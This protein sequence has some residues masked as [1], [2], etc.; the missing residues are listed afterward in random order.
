MSAASIRAGARVGATLL[1]IFFALSMPSSRVESQVSVS[2]TPAS[3]PTPACPPSLVA[4]GHDYHG[5]TLALCSFSG[6][7]LTNATFNGATL[8]GVVFIKTNLTGADFS[9]ATFADSGNATLPTDFTFANLTNAKLIG[10]KFNGATYFTYSTLTCADFSQTNINNGNAIFGDTPLAID[11]AQS[12]RTKF[13]NTTMNCEFVAQWNRLDL[14]GAQISACA[15]ELQ[16]ATG[17]PGYDFSGGLYAGVVFDNLDLA[18]SK[19]TGAVLEHASFQGATLDNA[20]GL[21]GTTATPSRLSAAKFNKASVQNV[22]LSNAQLYGA[23]FTNANLTNSCLAGSFLSA[24]TATTPPI[25]TA[26]V[27]DGAHLRNVNLAS[28]KLQGA[29]F[30]FASFYGSFGGATPAFPCKTNCAQPGFTCSC[31]TA[32]GA[33][34]TGANFSNAYLFGVDFTGATT[35][36]NGTQFGSAI[37]TGAS[38]A[39]A[40]FQVKGGAAPDFTKALLQGA[41]LDSTANL[42]NTSLL[43]AF[44]DFGAAANPNQGNILYLLLSADYTGFKG[45]SGQ[46]TPCVQA[47]YGGFS[48]V[49]PTVAMTCPNGSS[50]VCGAGKPAPNANANWKGGIAMATNQPVPGWYVADAT[51]DKAPSDQSVI[52]KNNATVD[53]NW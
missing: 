33:N 29:S 32:S 6:M 2:A 1:L 30:Q 14:T 46:S 42:V 8:T 51:Y 5:L 17:Q 53:P 22:D 26:A 40:Q 16:T 48:A 15:D 11:T 10:A 23:Q 34:L 44:V 3:G 20:T 45:W 24:N 21:S 36:I 39:G 9:G 7:D 19:W 27:F 28:A 12:C 31:A 18:A 25:E 37:L 35:T 13:Q 41:I 43:N 4:N 50:T 38:F 47:A 49:P 52:C